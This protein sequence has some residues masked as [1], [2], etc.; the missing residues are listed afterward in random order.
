[1]LRSDLAPYGYSRKAFSLLPPPLH[2]LLTSALTTNV[3][4]TLTL[5]SPTSVDAD[6][7]APSHLANL[8]NSSQLPYDGPSPGSQLPTDLD[9]SSHHNPSSKDKET[10]PTFSWVVKL[11][12][13]GLGGHSLPQT[14]SEH[15]VY[16]IESH[17]ES[18]NKVKCQIDY[19][20]MGDGWILF[21]FTTVH[22]REYVWLNRH[23]FVSGLNLV[24]KP[25]VPMLDPYA[26]SI[27]HVDQWLTITQLP[28]EYWDDTQLTSLLYEVGTFLKAD[29]YTLNRGKEEFARVCFNVDVTKP[30]RGTLTIPTSDAIL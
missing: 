27:T 14:R 22:D 12:M 28:Q 19:V 24:R 18:K 7:P 20:D 15:R 26:V 5:P 6:S 21:K 3:C 30:L 16:H 13:G 25:W 8:L 29:E 11:R 17:L 10:I 9:G 4:N 1:M 2:T 23:W